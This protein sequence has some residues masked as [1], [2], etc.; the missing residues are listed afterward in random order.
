MSGL[1]KAI[2]ILVKS[3]SFSLV[4]DMNE[5]NETAEKQTCN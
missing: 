1:E 3:D 5:F 4:A 2:E